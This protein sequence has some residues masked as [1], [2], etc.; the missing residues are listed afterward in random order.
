[1]QKVYSATSYFLIGYTIIVA[2]ITSLYFLP[3]P[4][5]GS[6]GM[7]LSAIIFVDLSYRYFRKNFSVDEPVNIKSVFY[8]MTY[9]SIL[10]ITLDILLMVIILPII[11]NG[12]LNWTF[13]S[14]QPI[15]YWFQFP[16]FYVFGFASQAIYNRVVS[17]TTANIDGI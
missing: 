6:L 1:M 9:W 7:V 3:G 4:V 16:M 2:V 10:S 12:T 14:Q 15:I 17:I 11:A 5:R 8:L 13:F